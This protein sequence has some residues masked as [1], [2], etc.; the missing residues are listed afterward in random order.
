[1]RVGTWQ[2]GTKLALFTWL[3]A[4]GGAANRHDFLRFCLHCAIMQRCS[5]RKWSIV[6]SPRPQ[7]SW[8]L[9]RGKL[10]S[11]LLVLL[12]AP[13]ESHAASVLTR[14]R[15]NGHTKR[16]GSKSCPGGSQFPAAHTGKELNR[17]RAIAFEAIA[18]Q[19]HRR[20]RE[21]S[22]APVWN[23]YIHH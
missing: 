16:S 22:S 6:T 17:P 19:P 8:I 23:R 21:L 13:R 20:N 10:Q 3:R 4:T 14:R 11:I 18:A 12:A 15:E 5:T 2:T 9:T 7:F 1:M